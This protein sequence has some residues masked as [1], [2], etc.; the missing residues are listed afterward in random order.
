MPFDIGVGWHCREDRPCLVCLGQSDC[1]LL[2]DPHFPPAREG[3]ESVEGELG[4]GFCEECAYLWDAF[5]VGGPLP[6]V[7]PLD[8]AGGRDKDRHHCSTFLIAA[9]ASRIHTRGFLVIPVGSMS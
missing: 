5:R 2:R 4:E 9:T 3:V 1:P 8:L 6:W 7:H